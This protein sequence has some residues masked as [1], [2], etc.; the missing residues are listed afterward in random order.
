MCLLVTLKPKVVNNFYA[1]NAHRSMETLDEA[2]KA[3]ERV[4]ECLEVYNDDWNTYPCVPS[5]FLSNRLQQQM[6]ASIRNIVEFKCGLNVP[7][8]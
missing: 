6:Y 8:P 3:T 1:S 5:Y 4:A 2:I 7:L